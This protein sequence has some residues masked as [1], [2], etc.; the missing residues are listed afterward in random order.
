[1]PERDTGAA[2]WYTRGVDLAPSRD[3]VVRGLRWHLSRLAKKEVMMALNVNDV[4]A[5]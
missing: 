5:G 1:M 2:A 4:I 3:F